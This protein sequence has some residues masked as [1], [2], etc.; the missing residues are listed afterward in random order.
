[1]LTCAPAEV[2]S[3][4]SCIPVQ[5]ICVLGLHTWEV[6]A[7]G[8]YFGVYLV[9]K[10]LC[11]EPGALLFQQCPKKGLGG[12]GRVTGLYSAYYKKALICD[13]F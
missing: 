7:W 2:P 10:V 13:S 5:R 8:K 9:F 12:G 6:S 11:T 3:L 1:M 4:A